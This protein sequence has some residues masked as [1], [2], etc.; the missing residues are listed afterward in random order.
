MVGVSAYA[1]SS[2][3][4]IRGSF[5]DVWSFNDSATSTDGMYAVGYLAAAKTLTF[6]ASISVSPPYSGD[7]ALAVK[8]KPDGSVAWARTIVA[9]KAS[10]VYL[11]AAATPGALYAVARC[12]DP[13]DYD[14]GNGAIVS[15]KDE[16][17]S[18]L[19]KYGADGKTQWAKAL[20]D[21]K[22]TISDMVSDGNFLY[23]AGEFNGALPGPDGSSIPSAVASLS[24]CVMKLDLKGTMLWASGLGDAG[25]KV[26]FNGIALGG[27]KLFAC[28]TVGGKG[29]LT[30]SKE[31]SISINTAGKNTGILACIDTDNGRVSWANV[32]S[33]VSNNSSF[34]K[35]AATDTTVAVVGSLS[36]GSMLLESEVALS[37]AE[38]SSGFMIS[39]SHEGKAIK[40]WSLEGRYSYSSATELSY[41]CASG[42]GFWLGGLLKSDN[43]YALP[44][45]MDA[46]VDNYQWTGLAFRLDADGK[47]DQLIMADKSSPGMSGVSSV[48]ALP[49]G[50]LFMTGSTWGIGMFTLSPG[51]SVEGSSTKVAPYALF[52]LP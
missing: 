24:A 30:L 36:Q 29:S 25:L 12:R 14:F 31:T 5:D 3:W 45:S 43:I 35:V 4:I 16:F 27:G 46:V 20:S 47:A 48:S 22:L 49:S 17:C 10:T 32:P 9:A 7:N 37:A 26:Y 15:T 34:M 39:F 41:I 44:G 51:I 2:P 38:K 18:V 28:G 52:L 42:S 11:C 23:L 6:G 33:V 50:A 21:K 19:V 8:Y 40:A 1:Q 13:G